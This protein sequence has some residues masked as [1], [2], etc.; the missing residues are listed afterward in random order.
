MNRHAVRSGTEVLVA[1][2]LHMIT[3]DASGDAMG[4]L[5]LETGPSWRFVFDADTQDRLH[6][7]VQGISDLS[8]NV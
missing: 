4:R 7:Y 2:L 6:S 1:V 3:S 5:C 8:I